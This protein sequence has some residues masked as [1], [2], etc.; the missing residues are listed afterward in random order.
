MPLLPMTTTVQHV[1]VAQPDWVSDRKLR[2]A[3]SPKARVFK[4]E[5]K[6]GPIEIEYVLEP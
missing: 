1:F 4:K 6:V 5:A 2:I 3:Y